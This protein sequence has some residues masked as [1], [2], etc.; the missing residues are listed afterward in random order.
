MVVNFR[1]GIIAGPT[2]P[3]T[4]YV[5]FLTVQSNTVSIVLTNKPLVFTIA[6]GP[7]NY[8][9][10]ITNDVPAA[11]KNFGTATYPSGV[12]YHLYVD[13]HRTTGVVTYGQ[14][15]YE[16]I[17]SKTAPKNPK[18]DQHW[19]DT[20]TIRHKVWQGTQW[21]ERIRLFF[22]KFIN[23]STIQGRPL[24]T[25]I[26]ITQPTLAGKIIYADNGLPVRKS[27]GEFFTTED[28]IFTDGKL[29]G[30]DTLDTRLVPAIAG[31][32]IPSTA[33][34]RFSDFSTV[35]LAEY[36]HTSSDLIGVARTAGPTNST[37]EVRFSGV[38]TN[39]Q[40][41]WSKPGALLWVDRNGELTE[42]DPG[43]VTTW[44]GLHPPVARALTPTD[45]WFAPTGTSQITSAETTISSNVLYDETLHPLFGGTDST[46]I[47]VLKRDNNVTSVADQKT[48]NVLLELGGGRTNFY[49]P[50]HAPALF[51]RS[52]GIVVDSVIDPTVA[53]SFKVVVT[54]PTT[55]GVAPVPITDVTMFDIEVVNGGSSDFVWWSGIKWAEGRQPVL[56]TVGTDL[57]RFITYNGGNP[58]YGIVLGQN[59]QEYVPSTATVTINAIG[60]YVEGTPIAITGTTN[61]QIVDVDVPTSAVSFPATV[62][63]TGNWSVTIPSH[64]T[65]IPGSYVA[66][67]T[68]GT[69]TA[70]R[71]YETVATTLLINPIS[72]ILLGQNLVINGTTNHR[73]VTVLLS[74]NNKTYPASVNP[75]GGTWAVQIPGDECE[76]G[77]TFSVQVSAGSAVVVREY[78]IVVPIPT[79]T[80]SN[81]TITAV[82][83]SAIQSSAV[84]TTANIQGEV[85]YTIAP[86]LPAGLILNPATGVVLGTPYVA[87]ASTNFT[88]TATGSISGTASTSIQLLVRAKP[89]V[90]PSGQTIIGTAGIT[91]TTQP[92]MVSNFEGVVTF[93]VNPPLPSGLT[94]NTTTGAISGTSATPVAT[95]TYTITALGSVYGSGTSTITLTMN[96][97][98]A[99]Q[100]LTQVIVGTVGTELTATTALVATGFDGAVTYT[101]SPNLPQGLVLDP[102]TGVISGTPE[103]YTPVAEYTISGSGSLQGTATATLSLSIEHAA[104][105]LT[106]SEVTLTGRKSFGVAPTPAFSPLGLG[107]SITYAISPALPAGLAFDTTTGTISGTPTTTQT[108]THTI[109]ASGSEYGTATALVVVVIADVVPIISLGQTKY[110]SSSGDGSWVSMDPPTDLATYGGTNTGTR[111]IVVG[112][113]NT[114]SNGG[115]G[116][117]LYYTDNGSVWNPATTSGSTDPR[118]TFFDTV[119]G[120]EQLLIAAAGHATTQVLYVSTDNG[121]TWT[122]V[123]GAP[124]PSQILYNNGTFLLLDT[125]KQLHRS[126]NGVDWVTVQG[127]TIVQSNQTLTAHGGALYIWGWSTSTQ[128]TTAVYRSVDGGVT[129]TTRSISTL[130]GVTIASHTITAFD[131]KLYILVGARTQLQRPVAI[132]YESADDG[133]TWTP[134]DTVPEIELAFN[135]ATATFNESLYVGQNKVV[136]YSKTPTGTITKVVETGSSSGGFGEFVA[137]KR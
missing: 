42:T 117:H 53:G 77:G 96:E 17:I 67:A 56:T 65:R 109:T 8:L 1:H 47:T 16:P 39:S 104:G 72:T 18:L 25:Q 43:L 133:Q 137:Y 64:S 92:M 40:W 112:I 80:P 70:T 10:T 46:A 36:E 50:V 131:G 6:Q 127:L 86:N 118:K 122:Q 23:S 103:V 124:P 57:V 73:V 120:T 88:V 89:N 84:L 33:V 100:P 108:T 27:T 22:G 98:P 116:S 129:W 102:N 107:G 121:A 51:S 113:N 7:T 59:M 130:V 105:T 24:G 20:T 91:I 106:P 15:R 11:W 62:T 115:A 37:I 128:N 5:N 21:V 95:T 101:I 126:T 44:R 119:C 123:L 66:T 38:V 97:A 52:N 111:L 35:S 85:T 68:A 3:T 76:V 12:D 93:S 2:T 82:V 28:S 9:F 48:T 61:Q 63:E 87:L 81:Q 34:V 71:Q 31:E 26:G 75:I 136:R 114:Y 134:W 45:V 83:G 135:F 110:M 54:G 4:G 69:A 125:S 132:I 79:I 19:F 99:I 41:N 78:T 13:I 90:A 60:S 55:L 30:P 29:Y 32:A 74:H 58:W 49:E 14:T 94:L